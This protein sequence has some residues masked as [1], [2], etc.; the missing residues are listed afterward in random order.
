MKKIALKLYLLAIALCAALPA[1][2]FAFD[3]F[4]IRDIRVD[5]IQ[6]IEAGTVFNY[7]PFK[8][9]ETMTD[10][11]AAQAI[12]ALFATGFFQDVRLEVEKDVLIILVEERPAIA[13]IDFVGLKEIKPDDAKKSLRDTGF[14]EG[15]IFDKALLDQA[16][17]ELKRHYQSRGY[18][19]SQVTTTVTPLE[20]NRV[21][22]NFAVQEGEV[23]K[24]RAI[25]FVG[26]QVFK[27]EDLLELITLRT[28]N[29]VSWFT[30]ND[31]YSRQKLSADLDTVRSFYLNRGFLDFNIDST[32]VSI[33]PDKRDIY[34]TINI[35]EGEKY[36]VTGIR[37]GGDM[38]VP[39]SEL[40]KLLTLK[41][42]ESFNREK[43]N[44]STKA[45][46]D[47]LGRDGY[48]FANINAV[49][50]LDRDKRTAEFTIMIDPGR[51]V[52]VRRINVVGNNRT[53]DEVIRREMRQLESAFY[54]TEKIQNSR[55]RL[56]RTSYFSE[57][58]IE[59]PPVQGTSD[60]VDVTVKVKEQPTGALLL[61]IGFSSSEKFVIQGSV[62]QNN[63]LGS[64]NSLTVGANTSK[65][66]TNISLSFTDPYYTVDGVSR[67]FD[68]YFRR[69]D[70]TSLSLG[71]YRT[72]SVGGGV[73]Y[74]YPVTDIDRISAGLSVERTTLETFASSPVSALNFVRDFGNSYT[75]LLATA[76]WQQDS[77]DSAVWPTNGRM[78][79]L[80]SETAI[81]PGGLHYF[82]AIYQ[83]QWFH[84][85]SRSLTLL[86]NGEVGFATGYGGK[87]LPFFKS[88][89]AGG[90][91][92]VR[93]Y[94]SNSLGP[95]DVTG[96]AL[97]GTRRIVGNAEL[98][99]PVPGQGND[100]SMR[101]SV[102]VDGGQ[103]FADG[104]KTSLG[105][106]RYSAGAGF[107]WN[108]PFGPMKLSFGT[109]MNKKE[110]DRIQRLQFQL[111]QIF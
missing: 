95:R 50:T 18:Y 20:R 11:K 75:S 43:L 5:G 67:G 62:S 17:Q 49:P 56:E 97:G 8:V 73:R 52:Y 3:P 107:A 48:A 76:G 57:V 41:L 29:W 101:L 105:D 19:A 69:S 13:A 25:N 2:T 70:P 1:T 68:A 104:A 21:G 96:T 78:Q 35:T 47:R 66:N 54:D 42:G 82:R 109:P 33:T 89:Y 74:G 15:R 34:I 4:V 23:S 27:E 22:I 58:G 111:G 103:V 31:Q 9:G 64:G 110:G 39:E 88:L 106:I 87:P 81:P 98:L 65:V 79:R 36:T 84:S 40:Q 28:P 6:R 55:K 94:D 44:E 59:T 24:I 30:K 86:L 93:A 80:T 71:N 63:V 53:R 10:E 38:L 91:G 61:G 83:N 51:R 32:Q 77:R 90:T 60:Q 108:S 46:S 100:R 37:F 14:Q 102:F 26:N 45:I 12:R 7:L 92:S 72:Q 16:E 99:F 85:F